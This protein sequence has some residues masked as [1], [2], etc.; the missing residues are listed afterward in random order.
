MKKIG[1]LC[2]ALVL[3]LGLCGCN[4]RDPVIDAL[5]AYTSESFYTS[6]GLQDFTDYAKYSYESVADEALKMT[7]YFTPVTTDNAEEILSHIENFEEWA[8]TVGG[9]VEENYDFD[10]I[11]VSEG[12]FFYI[13]TKAGDPIGQGMYGKFDNYTVYYFDIDTQIL[14]YFHHNI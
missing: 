2:L 9:E 6:G 7:T 4:S 11:L 13:K 8:E 5:P 1:L 3:M 10:K 12:D 14:Y